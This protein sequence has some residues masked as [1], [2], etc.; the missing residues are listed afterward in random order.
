MHVRYDY[1][2]EDIL[3]VFDNPDAAREAVRRVRQA[4]GDPHRVTAMPLPPGRYQVADLSLPEVVHGA[5]HMAAKSVPLGILAG[6]GLAAAAVP[7]AGA[8]A[9]AGLGLAGA[10]GGLVVGAMTGAIE[11]TRWDRDPAQFVEV[12]PDSEYMLVTVEASPA[13]GRRETSRV[14]GILVRAGALGFLDPGA[15]YAAREHAVA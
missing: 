1:E 3:A 8:L 13:P 4:I 15:Y 9:L 11:R 5:M 7:G 6:L 14:M 12:P 2:T 10:I